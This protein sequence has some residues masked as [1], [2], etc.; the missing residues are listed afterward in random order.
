MGRRTLRWAASTDLAERLRVRAVDLS[1]Y[2]VIYYIPQNVHARHDA[3]E[4][5]L[6]YTSARPG[7]IQIKTHQIT[8]RD[9]T[10]DK[11]EEHDDAGHAEHVCQ[12]HIP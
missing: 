12:G 3:N 9:A 11:P 7:E 5:Y 1:R 6:T 8:Q 10:L 4:Q 2:R